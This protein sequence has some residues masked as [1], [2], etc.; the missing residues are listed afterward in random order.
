MENR[1]DKVYKVI[2][3]VIITA[4]ITFMGTSIGM[5]NYFI[6]TEEGN[7]ESLTKFIEISKDTENLTQKLELVKKY[8]QKHY[9][10]ELNIDSM[11]E[12]AIKGYVSGLEDAYTEYL[13]KAEYEELL[14]SVTG[15]YVGIG[16]YMT[17]DENGNIIILTPIENSPAEL[18]DIQ[19]NDIILS[20][21]GESTLEM[22]LEEASNKIKGK[23]GTTVELELLRGTETIKKVIERKTVIIPDSKMEIIEGNIGY[24]ELATFDEKSTENVSRYLSEFQKKGINSV[25]I[26]LRSNTGGIV[27]EAIRFSELFV[28]K[29]RYN[30]AFI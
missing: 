16:I 8:L 6:E 12:N 3:L 11:T 18:G 4:I 21:N 20:I 24:I 19:P 29:R 7:I 17:Q 28:K 22:D 26:D 25:I 5:Y 30:N 10:G 9:I 23:E 2:M 1:K 15:D 14:V 13:T 27:T